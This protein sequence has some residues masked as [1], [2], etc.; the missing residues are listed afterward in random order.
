MPDEVSTG[1]NICFAYKVDI[2]FFSSNKQ[3]CK[4]HLHT[5]L[6]RLNDY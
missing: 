3:Q 6:T 1:L 2:L 4:E 5:L